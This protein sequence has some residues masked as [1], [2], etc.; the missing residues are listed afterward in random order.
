MAAS[1]TPGFGH[2]QSDSLFSSQS[3]AQAS[4]PFLS[5]AG[6]I[7]GA[8]ATNGNGGA[9]TSSQ[10][11]G[12][13]LTYQRAASEPELFDA[14]L[15]A[16]RGDQAAG[17]FHTL[18][19]TMLQASQS[20]QQ[21]PE[22]LQKLDARLSSG[23][24][25]TQ[26]GR[27]RGRGQTESSLSPPRRLSSTSSTNTA[28]IVE[29]S[30]MGTPPS[31]NR[32]GTMSAGASPSPVARAC[33]SSPP[34]FA[35]AE[36]PQSARGSSPS[37][38]LN[39]PGRV[40]PPPPSLRVV[41]RTRLAEDVSEAVELSGDEQEANGE[42]QNKE[43]ATFSS[44]MTIQPNDNDD[45]M[46]LMKALAEREAANAELRRELN[47]RNAEVESKD[48]EIAEIRTTVHRLE[49]FIESQNAELVTE[50]RRHAGKIAGLE[51]A[52]TGAA[53]DTALAGLLGGHNPRT[54]PRGGTERA[55]SGR[56]GGRMINS[57]SV[58]PRPGNGA[59][60]HVPHLKQRPDT[61][62]IVRGAGSPH[63]KIGDA[64][65]GGGQLRVSSHRS[66]PFALPK[67]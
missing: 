50:L 12:S 39:L 15:S 8:A 23:H 27:S 18:V 55:G 67:R 20:I 9:A 64:P 48:Q 51:R 49:A 29:E 3:S 17:Q 30:P 25:R 7:G 13:N 21:L 60:G 26:Q 38:A 63:G 22:L 6:P 10:A 45:H 4:P 14:A 66:G 62:G 28:V 5:A 41:N 47:E 33:E 56:R 19:A 1:G 61:N 24:V 2:C 43:D 11:T 53:P 35:L 42:E 16:L 32:S 46:E 59:N 58:S 34:S 44:C 54:L 52:G 40:S 37:K 65:Q 36:V 57:G 31:A